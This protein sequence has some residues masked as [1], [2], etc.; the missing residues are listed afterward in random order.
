VGGLLAGLLARWVFAPAHITTMTLSGHA[1]G[2]AFVAELLFTFA[3]VFVMLNVAT[4]KDHPG[5]SFYGLAIGFTILAGAVAVGSISG[6]VFNPAVFLGARPWL[7][8]SGRPAGSTWWPRC[9]RAFWPGSPSV[10]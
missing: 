2:A 10:H 5:N 4:S 1:L 6:S 8:S 9:S 3:L 7:R